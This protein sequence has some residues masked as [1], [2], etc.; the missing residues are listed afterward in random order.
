MAWFRGYVEQNYL[1]AVAE[2]P[3][4]ASI[5]EIG[6]SKGFLLAALNEAGFRR[7]HGV[8]LSPSDVEHA[9]KLVPNAAIDCVDAVEFLRTRVEAFDLILAKAVLEHVPKPELLSFVGAM[10][11]GL[12][13]GGVAIIDVPNMDWL[14]AAHERYMDLTH[15][16][17][18]TQESLRQTLE[19]QFRDVVVS[20]VD[21]GIPYQRLSSSSLRSA[22]RF[23]IARARVASARAVLGTLLRWAEPDGGRGPIWSRALVA[24]ARR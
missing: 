8:D 6:C 7:L 23:R 21:S 9:R 24:V 11:A 12:R 15:E 1:P 18:F 14:F 17:G 22:M 13:P 20:P 4:S 3:R 16:V 2:L 10:A 5:L 19:G